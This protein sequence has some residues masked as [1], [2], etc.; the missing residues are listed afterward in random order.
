MHVLRSRNGPADA[1]MQASTGDLCATCA[2]EPFGPISLS[3]KFEVDRRV[4]LY[5]ENK[6]SQG[7]ETPA[8]KASIDRSCQC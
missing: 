4:Y 8:T 5:S 2:L 1:R 7:M 3:Y 6:K